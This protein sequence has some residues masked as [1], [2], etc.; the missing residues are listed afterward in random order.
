MKKNLIL[1]Y[2]SFERGGVEK[3]V[4]NLINENRKFKVHIISSQNLLN[5]GI[6]KKKLHFYPVIYKENIPFIPNRFISAIKA[7]K[8][9]LSL[10]NSV[11]GNT[12]VHSMQS[13]VAAIIISLIKGKKIIIR[14]SEDPIYST[15]HSENKFFAFI[16]TILKF[17][18]YSLANGIITNSKGSAKNLRY[19]VFNKKKN[20]RIFHLDLTRKK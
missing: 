2:P 1:F 7:M 20:P 10:L 9:L 18:F 6:S 8:I 19:F 12:V 3:I 4:K 16:V 13:N 14:N 11:K 15:L 17:I 5:S